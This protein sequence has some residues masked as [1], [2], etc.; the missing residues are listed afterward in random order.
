M[1]VNIQNRNI[2]IGVV[3]IAIMLS[4]VLWQ[5]T[6]TLGQSSSAYTIVGEFNSA[7]GIALGN[8]VSLSGISVG[9]V[10]HVAYHPD[11]QTVLV[12]LSI[13]TGVELPTD[14][15]ASI[16]SD[17]F[18]GGKYVKLI[19]GGMPD[20]LEDGDSLEY[21]QGSVNLK[22]LLEKIVE[23]ADKKSTKGTNE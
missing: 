15:S 8:K 14:S 3:G 19:P 10:S 17:G 2:F 13:N 12:S 5:A 21:V 20:I 1:F 16:V 9:Q 22:E 23:G 11:N 18:F 4:V 6:Y 7:E